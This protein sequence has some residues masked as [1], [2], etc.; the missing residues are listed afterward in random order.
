MRSSRVRRLRLTCMAKTCYLRD[1]GLL[2]LHSQWPRTAH[3]TVKF[4]ALTTRSARYSGRVKVEYRKEFGSSGFSRLVPSDWMW[5]ERAE[6]FF[7]ALCKIVRSRRI[8]SNIGQHP[9]VIPK[10]SNEMS[11]QIRQEHSWVSLFIVRPRGDCKGYSS[12]VDRQM[13]HCS[14]FEL[15]TP[16]CHVPNNAHVFK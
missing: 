1:L 3:R 7:H 10:T 9:S 14:S 15:K 8:N 4:I 2:L 5:I 16:R 11:S 13:V 12:G 6:R